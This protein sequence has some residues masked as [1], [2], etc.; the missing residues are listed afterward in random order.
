MTISM[1]THPLISLVFVNYH[2]FWHLSCALESLLGKETNFG[3]YEVIIVNNDS[4]EQ[5]ALEQLS[6]LYQRVKIFPSRNLGF[7]AG[8][9]KGASI[10]R[11]A[12]LGFINPD[13]S[14]HTP[15]LAQIA[16]HFAQNRD[17]ILGLAL[18]DEKGEPTNYGE[19]SLPSLLQLFESNLFPKF[20]KRKSITRPL[21]W[22]SGGALFLKRSTFEKIEGFDENFFLYFEDVDFCVRAKKNNFHVRCLPQLSIVHKGGK[23]FTSRTEQKKYFYQSQR[24]YYE[25]HRSFFE[26]IV[27]KCLQNIFCFRHL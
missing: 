13:V 14:W 4:Q 17:D 23:S 10:A 2:S 18:L 11:G 1:S 25:K 24:L 5:L 26:R 9:N 16:E 21:M 6:R 19:E 3:Q 22:V 8:S 27:L 7:G 20:M 15:V 12:I